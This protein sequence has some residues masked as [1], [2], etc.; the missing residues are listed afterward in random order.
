MNFHF[1]TF[2][3]DTLAPDSVPLPEAARSS[4]AC[5]NADVTQRSE[6]AQPSGRL[7][8]FE[9]IPNMIIESVCVCVWNGLKQ[10]HPAWY[11]YFSVGGWRA[12]QA[13]SSLYPPT[14]PSTQLMKYPALP[15][16][17][18]LGERVCFDL[19]VIQ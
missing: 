8:H 1:W 3:S 2:D 16:P 18:I 10:L 6:R 12:H 19:N 15:T 4:A 9:N 5:L 7:S 13:Y 14:C 11:E 17:E